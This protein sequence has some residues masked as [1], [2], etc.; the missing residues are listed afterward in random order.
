MNWLQDIFDQHGGTA[1]SVLIGLLLVVLIIATMDA[2]K[3]HAS[4]EDAVDVKPGGKKGSGKTG[5]HKDT[6]HRGD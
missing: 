2:S 1:L 6:T 3:G 4:E 5:V